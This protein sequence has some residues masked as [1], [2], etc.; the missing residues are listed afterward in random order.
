MD[1]DEIRTDEEKSEFTTA[2]NETERVSAEVLHEHSKTLKRDDTK[3]DH[4]LGL[5]AEA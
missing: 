3:D 5:R 1:F 2:D 4:Q